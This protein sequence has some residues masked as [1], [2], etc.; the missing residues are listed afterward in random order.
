M[1]LEHQLGFAAGQAAGLHE[2]V[3]A[4]AHA[5]QAAGLVVGHGVH[6]LLFQPL[7]L[8]FQ[9][10]QFAAQ[11]D[12]LLPHADVTL[13][14]FGQTLGQ[15]VQPTFHAR[16]QGQLALPQPPDRED[17]RYQRG[18]QQPQQQSSQ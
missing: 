15:F 10:G 11:A 9:L 7:L 13:L 17:G 3:E 5:D 14:I 18:D 12:Q 1:Q 16:L 4:G 6:V 2:V 8:V